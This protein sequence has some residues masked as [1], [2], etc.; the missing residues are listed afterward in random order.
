MTNDEE[1]IAYDVARYLWRRAGIPTKNDKGVGTICFR[2]PYTC[3]AVLPATFH[4]V[5]G[6][7][8][9]YEVEIIVRRKTT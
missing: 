3:E 7:A 5:F 9:E 1:Q 6:D 2:L 8:V 4:P